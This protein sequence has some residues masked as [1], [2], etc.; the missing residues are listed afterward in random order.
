MDDKT[1]LLEEYKL[2]VEMADRI[3]SR[4][5]QTNKFYIS[6]LSGILAF[7]SITLEKEFLSGY[8]NLTILAISL[9]GIGFNVLWYINI[10][11]YRQ[12]NSGKF[13]VIHEMEQQLPFPCYDREWSLLGEGKD[14]KKYYQ[15]TRVEKYVP[16]F[17]AIPYLLLFVYSLVSW[18]K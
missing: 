10:Q 8:Q 15:L 11:S 9:L 5:A 18:I 12:L 4:R 6:I 13:K 1:I 14:S 2:Y 3:S 17:L 7:I 16:Y